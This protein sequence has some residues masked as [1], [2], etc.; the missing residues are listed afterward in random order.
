MK[1]IETAIPG[2]LIIEPE[3]Q[4]D[5]RGFFARTFDRRE[6]AERGLETDWRQCSVS[7]NARRGTVRGLHFQ[8]P[9]HEE[10][11]LLR[12]TRGAILDVI[13]DLRPWSSAFCRHITVEL[14]AGNH[15]LLYVPPGVA[16]GFQTLEDESEVFYQ[17]TPE[18]APEYARGVRYDD[19]AFG[20]AWPLPVT[21]ISPRDRTFQD[22]D[23]DRHLAFGAHAE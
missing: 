21:I 13:V 17:I 22:F 15:R 18:Y 3:P 4:R 16:H 11:K 10:T 5:D 9:P 1:L 20:I 6:F 23:H 19:P 8:A 7:F 2:A 12:C 14:T